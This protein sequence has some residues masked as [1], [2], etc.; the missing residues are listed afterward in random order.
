M[1]RVLAATALGRLHRSRLFVRCD[2]PELE[3]RIE[4]GSR[5]LA[6]DGELFQ[7][8]RT[9]LYRVERRQLAVYR[10][11]AQFDQR[12]RNVGAGVGVG[13]AGSVST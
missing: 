13:V 8:S 4:A 3:L 11:D 5:Q 1:V 6:V 9:I 10:P 12:P 2:E 7:G